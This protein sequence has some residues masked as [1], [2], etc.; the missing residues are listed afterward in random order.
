MSS[1]SAFIKGHAELRGVC[2]PW[3]LPVPMSKAMPDAVFE[4][5]RA[6]DLDT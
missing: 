4:Y 5:T 6:L 1:T 3:C 2:V